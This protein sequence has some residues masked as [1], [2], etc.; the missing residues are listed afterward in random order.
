MAG[1]IQSAGNATWRTPGAIVG[2]VRA[3]Y[4]GS[5][6]LDPAAS[7][8]PADHLASGNISLPAD[9]LN[10]EWGPKRVFVNPPFGT[11]FVK[12]SEC[13]TGRE[14]KERVEAGEAKDFEWRK[15]NVAQWVEKAEVEQRIN[16]AE[17]IILLPA[18][19]DTQ[20]W[21]AS[22]L[23][24]AGSVCL[25]C[26]RVKFVGAAAHAPMATALVYFGERGRRFRTFF[27]K[28]GHCLVQP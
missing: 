14:L 7:S 10:Q 13:I 15:Q 16:D 2:T 3:F 11:T 1:H 18:A 8:D 22:I 26:G 24:H 6:D 21:Q 25:I 23:Q 20:W 9:G 27:E 28:T 17:V 12:G 5:I 19:V 4:R